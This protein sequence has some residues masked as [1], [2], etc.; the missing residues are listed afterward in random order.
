MNRSMFIHSRP[1]SF[2]SVVQKVLG[3]VIYYRL[4]DCLVH[5]GNIYDYQ[6]GFNKNKSTYRAMI[7][8]MG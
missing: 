4:Y 5:V 2:L 6:F 8:F 1:I 3:K 7:F